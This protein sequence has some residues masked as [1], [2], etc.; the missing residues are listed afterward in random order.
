VFLLIWK[1]DRSLSVL[2]KTLKNDDY[3]EKL[4]GDHFCEDA[5]GRNSHGHDSKSQ[6]TLYVSKLLLLISK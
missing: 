4:I 1:R 6:E 5:Y 2:T 3:V